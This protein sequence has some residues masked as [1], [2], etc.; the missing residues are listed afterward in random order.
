VEWRTHTSLLEVTDTGVVTIDKSFHRAD[1]AADT[2]VIAVGFRPEQGLYRTLMGQQPDLYL[3]GDCREPRNIM[4]AIWDA[5]EV[6][7]SL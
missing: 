7:R 4:A 1:L 6:A 5:Y 3:I 2:V